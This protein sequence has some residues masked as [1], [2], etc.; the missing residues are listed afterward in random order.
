[1]PKNKKLKQI[2]LL[3]L[4]FD[5]NSSFE[6]G[7]SQA[8]K[9]IKERLLSGSLNTGT[10]NGTEL[11]NNPLWLNC[12]DVVNNDPLQFVEDI[13]SAC[14]TLLAEG[15]GVLAL[16]GDHSVTY[17]ILRAYAEHFNHINILHIDAHSDLYD[18]YKG[19]KLSN[20]CPFARI[21]EEGL[22]I[23]LVQIGIRTL[24]A[25]Q[26]QQ[27]ER[28]KV[29]MLEMKDWHQGLM[30]V[31][32]GPV[33]LSLDID[34][35]DPAFAPGVSHREPG[36]LSAREVINIIHGISSPLIGADIVEFN[37]LKDIDNMT[38]Q[39]AAKLVKEVAGK[40]LIQL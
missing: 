29:E 7:P 25:H 8:P 5:H 13:Q 24:N 17:P 18:S 21:M 11:K 36:G 9:V 37:P 19:N 4:P 30:P 22:C 20:A 1:M 12:E 39:L 14:S 3:G 26:R 23:R 6:R 15:T 32:E 16:G 33:Y 10:E 40:M 38:A 35:I 34:G 31:F 2:G 28:F 27:A